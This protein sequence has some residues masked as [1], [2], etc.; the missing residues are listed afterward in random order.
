VAV[1]PSMSTRPLSTASIPPVDSRSRTPERAGTLH[2]EARTMD[3]FPVPTLPLEVSQGPIPINQLRDPVL[4]TIPVAP[5]HS[6]KTIAII[7]DNQFQ[8]PGGLREVANPSSNQ[9]IHMGG[10][11]TTFRPSN[12]SMGQYARY[13]YQRLFKLWPVS[14]V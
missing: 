6:Q 2:R 10:V 8:D 3:T 9:G 5:R 12:C 14:P 1:L 11:A 4:V 7:V 13:G